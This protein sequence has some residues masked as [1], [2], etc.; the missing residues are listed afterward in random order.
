MTQKVLTHIFLALSL[1]L[2]PPS[3]AGTTCQNL[4]AHK[5]FAQLTSHKSRYLGLAIKIPLAI[6]IS[7]I[8]WQQIDQ[9]FLMPKQESA[10]AAET[11]NISEKNAAYF[12]QLIDQDFRFLS[13]KES[14]FD[15]GAVA[16]DPRLKSISIQKRLK[17]YNLQKSYM[18]YYLEYSKIKNS[19]DLS[20]EDEESEFGSNPLFAHLNFFFENGVTQYPGA[21]VALQNQGPIN[22]IKKKKLFELT[23]EMYN[24]YL[25]AEVLI[26]AKDQKNFIQQSPL[27]KSIYNDPYTQKLLVLYKE[28]IMS[29]DQ[30]LYFIQEDIQDAYYFSLFDTLKITNFKSK[31]GKYTNEPLTLN[32][33][34]DSRIAILQTHKELNHV[35]KVLDDGPA[36][37]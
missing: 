21:Y 6:A 28:K 2:S 31:D 23:H 25:A 24:E 26:Y 36:T 33:L 29:K 16:L 19:K 11:I 13:I 34:R 9:K 32:D 3:F 8:V 10:V 20:L 17:A 7:G 1:L 14:T 22:D 4:F 18:D 37:H 27:A 35:K 15:P 12:N 30:L 5:S